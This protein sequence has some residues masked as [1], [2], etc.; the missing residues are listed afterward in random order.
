[1]K[2]RAQIEKEDEC[3]ALTASLMRGMQPAQAADFLI[4]ILVQNFPAPDILVIGDLV[5]RHGW[6]NSEA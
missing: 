5:S 3:A 6:R 4:S 1:M 2:T